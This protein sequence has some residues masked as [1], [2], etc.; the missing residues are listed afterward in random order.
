MKSSTERDLHR[1]KTD[2][3][4]ANRTMQ[5]ACFSL[6]ANIKTNESQGQVCVVFFYNF[7][8]FFLIEQ[9]LKMLRG[10]TNRKIFL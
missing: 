5:N 7:L 2:L 1:L 3:S 9:T 10:E 4:Q 6:N 8:E